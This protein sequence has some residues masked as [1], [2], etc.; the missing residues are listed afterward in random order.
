MCQLVSPRPRDLYDVA[1]G[2]ARNIGSLDEVGNIGWRACAR[3]SN[4]PR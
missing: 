3:K 2:D 1:N 4:V